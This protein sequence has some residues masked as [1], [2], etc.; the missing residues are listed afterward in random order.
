MLLFAVILAA[1][2]IFCFTLKPRVQYLHIDQLVLSNTEEP[3][4]LQTYEVSPDK[5]YSVS[6]RAYTDSSQSSL[7]VDLY[8]GANFD[9]AEN[10]FSV[11]LD[12]SEVQCDFASYNTDQPVYIRL[13]Q[14]G[15]G[16]VTVSGMKFFKK[17]QP[18]RQAKVAG[19]I[20][21]GAAVVLLV[22]CILAGKPKENS[23]EGKNHRIV[24]IDFLRCTAMIMVILSHFQI[25]V[26]GQ[27]YEV[28]PWITNNTGGGGIY[29]R[30]KIYLLPPLKCLQ[31][32]T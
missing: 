24:F 9:S 17:S 18:S 4:V 16:T 26:L 21:F 12:N 14:T 6:L 8:G 11:P 32:P 1:A 19:G 5:D 25:F 20:S 13:I 3:Y 27:A 28:F 23:V 31:M 30:K 22:L 29:I 15:V 2:G 10:D 7:T